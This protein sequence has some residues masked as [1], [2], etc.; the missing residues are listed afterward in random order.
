MIIIAGNEDERVD[1]YIHCGAVQNALH[2][3]KDNNKRN[4]DKRFQC[5]L[6]MSQIALHKKG[7]KNLDEIEEKL[8][9]IIQDRSSLVTVAKAHLLIGQLMH[10]EQHIGHAFEL[11]E[12]DRHRGMFVQI[13]CID[14]MITKFNLS[15]GDELKKITQYLTKFLILAQGSKIRLFLKP[16]SVFGQERFYAMCAFYDFYY[17]KG[18]LYKLYPRQL[19]LGL[20]IIEEKQDC[21]QF[22]ICFDKTALKDYCKRYLNTK[23]QCWINKLIG[24][25]AEKRKH[26]KWLNNVDM[27]T[28]FNIISIKA[29]ICLSNLLFC[30]VKMQCELFLSDLYCTLFLN[31]CASRQC[32]NVSAFLQDDDYR[33]I[34]SRIERNFED[35]LEKIGSPNERGITKFIRFFL[36]ANLL[37][38]KDFLAKPLIECRIS[39]SDLSISFKNCFDLL[40]RMEVKRAV[41]E[42]DH[43]CHLISKENSIPFPFDLFM[44]FCEVFLTTAFYIS[45]R[46]HGKTCWFVVP[47]NYL[48]SLR[49]VENLFLKKNSVLEKISHD[50]K[51]EPESVFFL[52][53]LVHILCGF[54]CKLNLLNNKCNKQTEDRILAFGFTVL[55]NLGGILTTADCTEVEA[56]LA[57]EINQH[58]KRKRQEN[59]R[60][61]MSEAK[62]LIDFHKP[63][64]ELLKSGEHKLLWCRWDSENGLTHTMEKEVHHFKGIPIKLE[65]CTAIT[66]AEISSDSKKYEVYYFPRENPELFNEEFPKPKIDDANMSPSKK[67]SKRKGRKK[68]NT[69]HELKQSENNASLEK[70]ESTKQ[71]TKDCVNDSNEA[72]STEMSIED[73][74]NQLK[75]SNGNNGATHTDS[76]VEN[77]AFESGTEQNKL[78]KS[79]QLV[80][81]KDRNSLGNENIADHDNFHDANR[82]TDSW[83]NVEAISTASSAVNTAF[84]NNLNQKELYDGD[85]LEKNRRMNNSYGHKNLPNDNNEGFPDD[86]LLTDSDSILALRNTDNLLTKSTEAE[87]TNQQLNNMD[88]NDRKFDNP[89][90]KNDDKIEDNHYK[91]NLNIKP[92]TVLPE[93]N[94]S[95]HA[96]DMEDSDQHTQW[97]DVHDAPLNDIR[98]LFEVQ[99]V[100][101]MDYQDAPL[102]FIKYLFEDL[103]NE[104]T[105]STS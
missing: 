9:Q 63:L 96:N 20:K 54:S 23:F 24:A 33:F 73:T 86:K 76:Y 22:E 17:H 44:L 28:H 10:S 83:D 38:F 43:F 27:M 19:P 82:L 21:Q 77:V 5:I 8:K 66:K 34:R 35:N 60:Q 37:D 47:Q 16:D 39:D 57:R 31:T 81:I 92:E 4:K 40:V 55:C 46:S 78:F 99:N 67:S 13:E 61:A 95:M 26:F 90:S 12:D 72:I 70:V 2:I 45:V 25:F 88:L 58:L 89:Y 32:E 103:T 80:E 91:K 105:Y 84:D 94:K 59:I 51:S 71:R 3:L 1:F 97:E 93:T 53:H 74:K 102:A 65:T 101:F 98:H 11:L 30:D 75:T 50:N 29:A 42:F 41:C 104:D 79:G 56:N 85:Q 36:M 48:D 87:E 49:H 15:N 7:K 6:V 100:D 69:I 52:T 62:F 68:R 14:L 18:N 64:H